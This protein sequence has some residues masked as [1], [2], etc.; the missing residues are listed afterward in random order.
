MIMSEY[1]SLYKPFRRVIYRRVIY[2]LGRTMN[3]ISQV[4]N[5]RKEL[6]NQ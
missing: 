3:L 4:A 1:S 5:S 6:G 2:R